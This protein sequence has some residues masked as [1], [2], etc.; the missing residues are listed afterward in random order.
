MTT[1]HSQLINFVSK[2]LGT[3]RFRNDQIAKIMGYGDYQLGNVTISQVYY[4]EGLGQNLFSVGQ[5]C[6]L[7][8]EVAFR[9]HTCYVRNLDDDDLVS[10]S[11]DTNLYTI[12]LDNMLKSSLICLLSKSSKT[13]SW[14]WNWQLSHL[15]FGKSKKSSHKSKANKNNQEKLY[16][17]HMNLCGPMHMESINEKKYI[18][19]IVDDYSRFT[20]VKFLR[21]K[22]EAPEQWLLNSSGVEESPKIAHFHDNPLHET[23]HEDS[24]SQGSS[25]NVRPSH[26]PFELLCRWT[27][28]HPIANV[29]GDPSHSVS[30]RKQLKTDAMWCYFDAF[31]TL[32]KPKNFEETMLESSWIDVMQEEIHESSDSSLAYKPFSAYFVAYLISCVINPLSGN[33]TP[34]LEPVTKSSSSPTITSFE[35]SDL[36]WEEFKAY[37]ISDSFPPGN[38]DPVDLLLEKFVDE[39]ALITFPPGNDDL[40]FDIESDLREI[41]YFLNHDPTKEMDSILEDSVDKGN[42]ADP[43]NDLVDTI[44]EMFTDEHALDYSSPPLYDDVDDDLCELESDNDNVYDDPFDSKE[45]KI[46]ESKLLID[47]LDPPRSSD[48]ILSPKSARVFR[49]RREGCAS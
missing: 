23:L 3:V 37:L 1:Q 22:D 35:E 47:E 20:W 11:R 41:K 4:V 16:L 42:L 2:F 14:L 26:T 28:I 15:N 48:F 40:P 10:K 18:L 29:I 38:N 12:S 43:N 13:K 36:I 46:K 30:I 24:T 17:L 31:L 33:P 25:S 7:D 6:D 9:K 19:V 5:L 8:L 27:K 39:L 45:D 21:S 32:V 49:V 34:I 44:P